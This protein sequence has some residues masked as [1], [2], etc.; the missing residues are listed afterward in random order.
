MKKIAY[1][2]LILTGIYCCTPKLAPTSS[3][4][5]EADV[6]R[7]KTF[8][9]ECNMEKLTAAR[10]L[11][12]NKCGT[13]HSLK[14]PDSRSEEAWRKIVPPMAQK[15]KLTQEEQDMVLAYVLTM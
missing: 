9:S 14:S 7:G 11:Y 6:T 1:V 5:T 2:L 10:T 12:T 3:G 4:F 15:A 8:W 13:C